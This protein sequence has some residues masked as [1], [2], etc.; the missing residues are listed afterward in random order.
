[1]NT[2]PGFYFFPGCGDSASKRDRPLIK[3]SIHKI[4][5]TTNNQKYRK[6]TVLTSPPALSL[7]IKV[8]YTYRQPESMSTHLT[9]W[10]TG[11][12]PLNV[13][14]ML[15]YNTHCWY[16]IFIRDPACIDFRARCS[17]ASELDQHL[18]GGGFYLS[19]YS[20][21][22]N[23]YVYLRALTCV[24]MLSIVMA[25]LIMILKTCVYYNMQAH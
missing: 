14:Y 10:T 12:A 25:V 15:N 1:M 23:L 13:K 20:I 21:F 11:H 16:Q 7:A 5:A 24:P 18:F 3:T 22:I 4:S 17:S 8:L 19:K 2:S 9:S 6:M